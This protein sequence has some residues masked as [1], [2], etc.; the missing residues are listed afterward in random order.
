MAGI[1][2]K[3]INQRHVHQSL[4]RYKIQCVIT[5]TIMRTMACC[6]LTYL[7]EHEHFISLGCTLRYRRTRDLPPALFFPP[8]LVRSVYTPLLCATLMCVCL[9]G[10]FYITILLVYQLSGHLKAIYL[11]CS[12]ET[13]TVTY[14]LQEHPDKY[15]KT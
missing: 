9:Y 11:R 6:L 8:H 3:K 12:L 14:L 10:L 15:Y 13:S 5:Y 2:R 4:K 7:K 1:L